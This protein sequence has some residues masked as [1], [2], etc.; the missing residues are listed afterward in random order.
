MVG[1]CYGLDHILRFFHPAVPIVPTFFAPVLDHPVPI[2]PELKIGLFV[3]LN[4]LDQSSGLEE[5]VEIVAVDL[6][7][8]FWTQGK[9]VMAAEL[10]NARLESAFD[11]ISGQI[12]SSI[13]PARVE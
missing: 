11:C 10:C 1:V 12:I 8:G 3:I 4:S 2:S 6:S 5:L 7:G 9:L 13:V